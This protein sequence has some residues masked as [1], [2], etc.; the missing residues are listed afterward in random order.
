MSQP[1]IIHSETLEWETWAADQIE[2]RGRVDWRNL[3]S[4]GLTDTDSLTVGIAMV[5]PGQALKPHHHSP[6]EIYLLIKGEAIMTLGEQEHPVRAGDAVFIPGDMRHGIA[7]QSESDVVF[8][9]AFARDTF[10]QVVYHFPDSEGS[11]QIVITNR[12]D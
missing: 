4:Q 7:N 8:L 3:F 10:E 2:T 12:N 1:L 9:Y 6:S 5:H 11:N